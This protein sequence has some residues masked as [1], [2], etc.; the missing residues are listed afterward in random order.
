[1]YARL[2]LILGA[3]ALAAVALGQDADSDCC[4]KQGAAD[5]QNDL[6]LHCKRVTVNGVTSFICEPLPEHTPTVTETPLPTPT[7][8]S[9]GTSACWYATPSTWSQSDDSGGL[10]WDTSL[11]VDTSVRIGAPTSLAYDAATN[12]SDILCGSGYGY[13][14]PGTATIVSV[15]AYNPFSALPNDLTTVYL[16]VGFEC[17]TWASEG[18]L[19]L[20]RLQDETGTMVGTDKQDGRVLSN[21][22]GVFGNFTS[23]LWGTAWTPTKVNSA[24]FGLCAK[25]AAWTTSTD[26]HDC[27]IYHITSYN[28]P[29]LHPQIN[30]RFGLVVCYTTPP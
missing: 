25:A 18:T 14:I 30:A 6:S 27:D 23:D 11:L 3:L 26:E 7:P 12:H 28:D 2:S 10:S 29:D 22:S 24:N 21:Y 16:P 19:A 5:L 9:G 1:M 13:A 20:L 15:A 4:L 8:P 17:D